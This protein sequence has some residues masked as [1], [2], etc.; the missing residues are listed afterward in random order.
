MIYHIPPRNQKGKDILAFWDDFL[1][2]DQINAILSRPEWN[3]LGSGVVGGQKNGVSDAL[4]VPEIRESKV[5]WMNLDQDNAGLWEILSKVVAEVNS[6]FFHFD[7]TGMYEPIQL[8]L[9]SSDAQTGGHYSWHTDMSMGDR[10]APRKLSMVLL[11]SDPTEFEG[12]EFEVKTSSDDP[13]S[14]E[15]KKGR[16]WFFPSWALHRVKPVTKGIRK[17]MV[18]WVAGPPFK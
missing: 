2:N 6:E 8:S 3:N 5:A 14:V 11:L 12:G 18:I 4:Y 9:Y 1:T 17:S 15:Q 13:I 16:A 7:L 10:H